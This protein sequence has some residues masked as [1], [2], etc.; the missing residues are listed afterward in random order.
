VVSAAPP[1]GERGSRNFGFEM[2]YHREMHL[3]AWVDAEPRG[4]RAEP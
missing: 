1:T 2:L 3:I 4:E